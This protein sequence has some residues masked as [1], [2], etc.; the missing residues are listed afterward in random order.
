MDTLSSSLR[1]VET[2]RNEIL[3]TIQPKKKMYFPSI[4][5]YLIVQRSMYTSSLCTIRNRH[6]ARRSSGFRKS[7]GFATIQ[8]KAFKVIGLANPPVFLCYE[9][10]RK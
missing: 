4:H 1:R 5:Y 6:A 3:N 9:N 7:F 10:E 2:L 8:Y